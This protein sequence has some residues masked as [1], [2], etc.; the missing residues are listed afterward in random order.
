MNQPDKPKAASTGGGLFQSRYPEASFSAIVF[1]LVFGAIMNAAITYSGL[2]IGFTITGTAIAAV[3]GFGVLRG[4]LRRGSIL[5]VNIGQTV[6]SAIN[7]VN[8]GVI[9]TIPALFLLG[10]RMTFSD[11]RFWLITLACVAGSV[12]GVVF[13]VPLRKQ[14][15]DI[16]R[17]RFPTPTAVAAILKAPGAGTA[18]SVVLV[19]GILVGM[20]VYAP[21]GL[22][23][24]GLPGYA[25][26]D[27]RL[28]AKIDPALSANSAGSSLT[29]QVDRDRDGQPD[30]VVTNEAIDVGRWL[31]LPDSM[32]LAF[33]IAPFAFGAGFLTGRP[34]L[35]VLAGGVLAY[36][37]LNPLAY[38]FGW[39]PAT[40][41]AHQVPAYALDAYNRPLGI[42]MLLGGALMGVVTALPSIFEAVKSAALASRQRAGLRAPR[43]EI[44]LLSLALIAVSGIA[45]LLIVVEY[46]GGVGDLGDGGWLR[47][48]D[49]PVAR[50]VVVLVSVA[51][52]W[53]AGIIVSQCSGMTD[54]SPM[55][56][57][58][59]L[60]VV[61]VMMLAGKQA[62]IP[63]VMIG[64]ALCV[65]ISCATDMMGDL[66]TGYLVGA[67]PRRQQ[68]LQLVAGTLGPLVTMAT[69]LLIV[70]ANLKL[71]GL[72]IGP[73]T[74]TEAPQAQ[75]LRAVIT[76]VQGG[77]MP[78]ALYGLGTTLGVLLGLGSFA[79]LGVLIGLSMYLKFIHILTYGLGCV[80]NIVVGRIKG[81]AWA[82]AWG[83]PFCAGLIV[84]EALLALVINSLVLVRG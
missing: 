40:V 64:A 81:R 3:M 44:G 69:L 71:T 72:P 43:D 21:S 22:P 76:G 59:L 33:A 8:A 79:G 32:L 51:W 67:Q 70:G 17:L 53:F 26:L 16:E 74:P 78:Y 37:I 42:G 63:A 77:E 84:G 39:I 55:S 35:L 36:L 28:P 29:E 83:V 6:A 65:A 15:L 57:M 80:T 66:K 41:R 25:A 75:A 82:E 31:G 19:M 46:L 45:V 47:S 50:A 5:E 23:A 27:L 18:K 13:I 2:K 68:I 73:G 60:T 38:T 9:F 56:G 48:L 54:W 20:I 62:V 10:E 1:G 4:I 61:L 24:L 11:R 34:G 30:L 58:A 49:P 7:V 52:I 12:L 14:M